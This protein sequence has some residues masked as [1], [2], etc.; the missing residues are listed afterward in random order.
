MNET[1][2]DKDIDKVENFNKELVDEACRDA[3]TYIKDILSTK[4]EL[5]KK[6]A[7]ILSSLVILIGL[8]SKF[9][10]ENNGVLL[11]EQLYYLA[12]GLGLHIIAAMFCLSGFLPS[13]YPALGTTPD[14]WVKVDLQDTSEDV[15]IRHKVVILRSSEISIKAGV[16]SNT[17][18]ASLLKYTLILLVPSLILMSISVI[19]GL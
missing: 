11:D 1:A 3:E 16:E 7:L 9:I 2:L 8:V 6:L 5:E 4:D 13:G 17:A 19:L 10:L 12:A 14:Y 18:K 15:L